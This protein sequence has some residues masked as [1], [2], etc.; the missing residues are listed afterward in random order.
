MYNPRGQD[1]GLGLCS[2]LCSVNFDTPDLEFALHNVLGT[3]FKKWLQKYFCDLKA[4]KSD[5]DPDFAA[6]SP[7]Q[8]IPPRLVEH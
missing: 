1:P 8:D 7:D 2:V 5:G 4:P 6:T 3:S